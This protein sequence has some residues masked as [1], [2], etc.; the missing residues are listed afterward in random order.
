MKFYRDF[1]DDLFF[2]I[3]VREVFMIVEEWFS[4]FNNFV[5]YRVLDFC[6]IY[7]YFICSYFNRDD[8]F[9]LFW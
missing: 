1:Y 2:D 7:V 5:G 8:K 6:V 3:F 9:D 4:G